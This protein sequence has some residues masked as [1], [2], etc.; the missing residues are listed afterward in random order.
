MRN[1]LRID[2]SARRLGSHTK[3]LGDHA[4]ALWRAQNPDGKVVSRHVGD[5]SIPLI[6]PE[7]IT[8]FFT[9]PEQI[10]DDLRK[11]TALSDTLIAELQAAD[12]LLIT[13]PIYNFGPPAALKAWIDLITRIG[14]TFAYENGSFRGLTQTRRAL[15]ICAYGAE[16]YLEGQP[17]AAGNFLQPYLNFLLT[18]LGIQ[19]IKF[20]SIQ[21]TTAD[22]Q[23]VNRNTT[24]AMLDVEAALK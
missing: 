17:F 16:G 24:L 6:S 10:T 19:D 18:F 22:E 7:T 14:H 15:V 4:E 8:G 21:A 11:A 12:T 5:G 3:A 1:L 13:A 20:V 9:P 23:T 2:S